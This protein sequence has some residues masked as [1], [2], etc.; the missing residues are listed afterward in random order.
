MTD[1]SRKRA[2][3]G[4]GPANVRKKLRPSELPLSQTKRSAIDNLVHTFKRK[5]QYDHIRKELMAQYSS[6]VGALSR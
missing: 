6:G 3:E 1:V 4:E 2:L 5:G